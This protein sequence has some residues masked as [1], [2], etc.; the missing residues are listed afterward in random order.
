MERDLDGEAGERG[1]AAP[2]PADTIDGEEPAAGTLAEALEGAEIP[3]GLGSRFETLARVMA[4]LRSPD[5]C[6]WDLEQT[7]EKLSRH[8]LEEAYETVDAIDTADWEHVA[9][10][11]GDLLLQIVFQSRVAEEL[12]RFDLGV[13]VDGITEKLERRHPHIFGQ[14][15]VSTAEQVTVNWERIKREEEGKETRMSF[16][17]SLP[18]MMAASKVQGQ[19]ARE[20]FDWA[21]ADGVLHKLDEEIAELQEARRG[22]GSAEEIEHEVGDLLFTVVNLARHLGVDPERALRTSTREFVRRYSLMEEEARSRGG[23]L[24]SMSLDDKERMWQ[25]AKKPGL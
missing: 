15:E 16:P 1:W 21:A 7:P 18:S 24:A 17:P 3:A 22:Q 4:K 9:E 6:P 12:E 23:D 8:L 10:E 13:V 19:A 20:G 5:G 11:L 2:G 25:A 14:T